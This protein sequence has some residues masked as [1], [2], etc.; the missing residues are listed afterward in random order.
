MSA[1]F[2]D[3]MCYAKTG[4]AAHGMT[5][6]DKLMALRMHGSLPITTITGVPP[7]SFLADGRPL[8]AWT[9]AGNRR[10]DGTLTFCGVS[11]GNLCP[12]TSF[13]KPTDRYYAISLSSPLQPGTYTLSAEITGESLESRISFRNSSL[14]Q[15]TYVNIAVQSGRSSVTVTLNDA[16]YALYIY[17]GT[18]PTDIIPISYE[19]IMLNDGSTALH[20]EPFG[21]KIP[22]TC[23][24]Q[25]TPIYIG[26]PLRKAIDG[27]DAVDVL[28]STGTITREVDAEGNAL[29]T[30]TTQTI[31]V[32]PEIRT[33]RGINTLSVG[34]DLQPSSISITWRIKQM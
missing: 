33:V 21:Y 22:I 28:S 8:S 4:I 3:L 27:T 16:C 14:L 31:D 32:P 11:T 34:T 2:Y 7:L 15:I 9:I 29:S 5:A 17:G 19:D 10:Q 30:P 24:G 6:Y 25:T 26:D 13:D 23:D 20:Y 12:V 18:S 1:S